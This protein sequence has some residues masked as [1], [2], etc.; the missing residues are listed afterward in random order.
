MRHALTLLLFLCVTYPLVST[1]N[2]L[3]GR[4]WMFKWRHQLFHRCGK[5]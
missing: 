2:R 3:K 1:M 5:E 4:S